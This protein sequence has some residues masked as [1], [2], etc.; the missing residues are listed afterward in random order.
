MNDGAAAPATLASAK[1]AVR[2]TAVPFID[3]TRDHQQLGH[4]LLVPP[5]LNSGGDTYF[6]A[7]SGTRGMVLN[8][9]SRSAPVNDIA[10]GST[11]PFTL[12]AAGYA[13]YRTQVPIDQIG[14]QTELRG[15]STNVDLAVRRDNAA[16]EWFN[17]AYSE[18]AGTAGD[19]VTLVPPILTN[20]TYYITIYN[21]GNAAS[22][23]LVNRVPFSPV[24]DDVTFIG[25]SRNDEAGTPADDANPN[26]AGWRYFRVGVADPQGISEQLR[27]LGWELALS[28]APAGTE[29]A[30][31]RNF[32]PGKWSYRNGFN[33][34]EQGSNYYQDFNSATGFLQRP[35]HQADIWYVGIYK[36]GTALGNFTL[37][38]TEM[39]APVVPFANGQTEMTNHPAGTWR[40]FTVE[41]PEDAGAI[42]WDF[43]TL[44]ATGLITVEV[45]RGSPSNSG[46]FSASPYWTHPNTS[47]GG[48]DNNR[49]L[50]LPVKMT[51]DQPTQGRVWLYPAPT[52][53]G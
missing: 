19:S 47:T 12:P 36:S 38:R 14:W 32:L 24:P 20:G 2:R 26:K 17:D 30:L 45:K 39:V 50:L 35:S 22:G 21:S 23:T 52:T 9:D 34:N 6:L 4:M 37:A 43:R 29:I 3:G 33:G 8:L 40:Y 53:S 28:G 18:V 51:P 41:V 10:F 46:D 7:V 31:R 42:G 44:G 25:T 1:L 11:T 5:Y 16:S 13:V 27:K 49:Y 15:L 48:T